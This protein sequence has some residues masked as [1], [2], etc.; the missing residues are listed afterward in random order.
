MTF[1][2]NTDEVSENPLIDQQSS[3]SLQIDMEAGSLHKTFS[4][5]GS[6][7]NRSPDRK[8]S[9]KSFISNS[10]Q[11]S[12]NYAFKNLNRSAQSIKFDLGNVSPNFPSQID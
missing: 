3:H 5:Q 12:R 2:K 9:P 8:A 6:D 11:N 7:F 10:T 4:D 1:I